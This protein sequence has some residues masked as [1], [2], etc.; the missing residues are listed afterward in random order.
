MG[1]VLADPF[2]LPFVWHRRRHDCRHAYALLLARRAFGRLVLPLFVSVAMLGA[3]GASAR[4]TEITDVS[5]RSG[6][7][8]KERFFKLQGDLNFKIALS[9]FADRKLYP[10]EDGLAEVAFHIKGESGNYSALFVPMAQPSDQPKNLILTAEGPH[11]INVV[12]GTVTVDPKDKSVQV[13]NEQIVVQ[14][15]V[16]VGDG[17]L[18][19]IMT[20]T[21]GN[22]MPAGFG[23]LYGGE[24]WTPCFCLWCGGGFIGC[25][26]IH[27]IFQ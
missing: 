1:P 20:C 26:I 5:I 13:L 25:A 12:L 23:C 16:K 11:G 7:Q 2:V 22:C 17:M 18:K 10:N 19:N 8:L 4:S 24:L 21:L 27:G 14:G 9:Y 3:S 6:V 15:T